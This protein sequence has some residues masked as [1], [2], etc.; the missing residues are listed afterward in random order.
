MTAM[1]A[2]RKKMMDQPQLKAK[3]AAKTAIRLLREP[4][5]MITRDLFSRVALG[6]H[7]QADGTTV[8]RSVMTRRRWIEDSTSF[9]STV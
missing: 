6:V 7:Q 3:T 8:K 1:D 5:G 2:G 4:A 9:L